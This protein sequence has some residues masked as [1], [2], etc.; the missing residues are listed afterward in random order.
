MRAK[1]LETSPFPLVPDSSLSQHVRS[2]V[3]MKF[4]L[5]DG[6][7]LILDKPEEVNAVKPKLEALKLHE[8][9]DRRHPA[10][11]YMITN[12][13]L[14]NDTVETLEKGQFKKR[15]AAKQDYAFDDKIQ[16]RK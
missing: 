1:N 7:V 9:G 12:Q 5:R 16:G 3:P 8:N 13:T 11:G 10:F 2:Y 6:G 4:G 15:A 14:W